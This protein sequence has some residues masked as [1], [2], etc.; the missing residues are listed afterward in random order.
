[1][2]E[3]HITGYDVYAKVMISLLILTTV[4]IL[5]PW[6]NLSALTVFIALFIAT[7]KGGIVMIWFM[8]LK[9]EIM[10]I[11]IFVIFIILVYVS[12]ILLTFSDYLMRL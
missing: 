7:T 1:M 4:T 3:K 9:T 5:V 12:V 6:I 11:K 2:E 8:H 10:L